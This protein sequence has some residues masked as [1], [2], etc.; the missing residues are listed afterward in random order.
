[1]GEKEA[2]HGGCRIGAGWVRVRAALTT[3]CPCMTRAVNRPALRFDAIR[4]DKPLHR[5]SVLAACR[6]YGMRWRVD[7]RDAGVEARY[8]RCSVRRMHRRIRI[9]MKHDE[10]ALRFDAERL[11]CALPPFIAASAEGRSF[12]LP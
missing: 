7:C 8:E 4:C 9:A 3:A 10:R 2:Q 11:R 12:A 5:A 1:M 6:A